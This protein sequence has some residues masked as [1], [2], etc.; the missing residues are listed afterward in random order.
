MTRKIINIYLETGDGLWALCD[1][2][3]LWTMRDSGT[4]WE[5]CIPIPQDEV[6]GSW[7]EPPPPLPAPTRW[8]PMGIDHPIWAVAIAGDHVMALDGPDD[9]TLAI[10]AAWVLVEGKDEAD[11]LRCYAA[12]D[13]KGAYV[14]KM[15]ATI[16]GARR[17]Y[18]S[19]CIP[20]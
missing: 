11:A 12:R 7:I 5:K 8:P 3:T 6:D 1:D 4:R 2:G 17:E 19:D 9:L 14:T 18:L 13:V 15:H 10:D 20:F 16:D